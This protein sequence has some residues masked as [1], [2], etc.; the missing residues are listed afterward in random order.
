MT[1]TMWLARTALILGCMTTACS[2]LPDRPAAP[3][4]HDFGPPLT[5]SRAAPHVWSGV[6]VQAPDWLH[7]PKLRYRLL[8]AQPTRVQFYALDRWV[9]P[10]PNLLAQTLSAAAG[11][12]GC[13][14]NID[15]QTFEQVFPQ[16][17]QARVIIEFLARAVVSTGTSSESLAEQRFALS[18]ACP[19]ANAAGAVAAY[20]LAIDEAINRLDGW[21]RT[22]PDGTLSACRSNREALVSD[23]R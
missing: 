9:A 12:D 5:G 22:L 4:V 18:R 17:G 15:L 16:P 7:D 23:R 2:L 21:L 19:T 10:P 3:A 8:Y 11:R 20:S 1:K 14:L 13:F 6:A